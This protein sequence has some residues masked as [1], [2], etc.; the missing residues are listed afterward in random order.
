[1]FSII[2]IKSNNKHVIIYLILQV[3][4]LIG[5]QACVKGGLW[6]WKRTSTYSPK[7]FTGASFFLSFIVNRVFVEPQ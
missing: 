4:Q 7:S 6:C 2:Y 3:L 1:M 5:C